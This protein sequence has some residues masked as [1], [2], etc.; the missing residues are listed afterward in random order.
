MAIRPPDIRSVP[1]DDR[2]PNMC[3][4][5]LSRRRSVAYAARRRALPQYGSDAVTDEFTP[6]LTPSVFTGLCP[7]W[8]R[9]RRR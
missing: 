4:V 1:K 2:R 3:R 5:G 8:C 6:R 9:P 7:R